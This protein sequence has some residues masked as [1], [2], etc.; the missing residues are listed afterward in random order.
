MPVQ[1]VEYHPFQYPKKYR[2]LGYGAWEP[3]PAPPPEPLSPGRRRRMIALIL[4]ALLA[5]IVI[6][7]GIAAA[8]EGHGGPTRVVAARPADVTRAAAACDQQNPYSDPEYA[9]VG[10]A[11]GATGVPTPDVQAGLRA[12]L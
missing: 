7:V 9:D 12:R 6:H 3:P 10:Q 8:Y 11:N 2:P 1:P 5:T 4:A